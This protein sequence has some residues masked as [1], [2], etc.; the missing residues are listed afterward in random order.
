VLDGPVA[1]SDDL[2]KARF[3]GGVEEDADGLSHGR[4]LARRR[5]IVNPPTA[6]MH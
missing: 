4:R 1:I 2:L 5:G 3:I 6:S